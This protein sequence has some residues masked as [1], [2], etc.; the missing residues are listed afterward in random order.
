MAEVTIEY[1]VA[2][3]D[4]AQDLT[5]YRYNRDTQLMEPLDTS[6]DTASQTATATGGSTGVEETV[7]SHPKKRLNPVLTEP[8]HGTPARPSLVTG[9]RRAWNGSANARCRTH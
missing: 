6:V 5:V 2:P 4:D 7:N 1:D 9:T 8:R 3:T